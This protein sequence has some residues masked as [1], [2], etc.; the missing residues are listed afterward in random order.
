MNEIFTNFLYLPRWY[1]FV[2]FL[3]HVAFQKDLREIKVEIFNFK[4]ASLFF[5]EKR[6]DRSL[7]S[8]LERNMRYFGVV[9]DVRS[10]FM[11]KGLS[12]Q[13]M[14]FNFY[15]EEAFSRYLYAN[16]PY[17]LAFFQYFAC[18]QPTLCELIFSKVLSELQTDT[19]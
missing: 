12:F 14:E 8:F 10:F 2:I 11:E 7:N 16:M 1:Y 17:F 18:N 13:K 5:S 4:Q 3:C 6:S 9:D 15:Y 19:F